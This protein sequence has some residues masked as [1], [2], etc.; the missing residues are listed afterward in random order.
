MKRFAPTLLLAAAMC[1][2]PE[3]GRILGGSGAD[4]GNRAPDVELHGGSRMYSRTPCMIPKAQCP[5][6]LP[7]SGLSTDFPP[8][9]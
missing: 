6:P 5:G 1:Q 9:R 3:T 7:L 4:V 2:S 8:P